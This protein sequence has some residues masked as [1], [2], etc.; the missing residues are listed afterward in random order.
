MWAEIS[1]IAIENRKTMDRS[2]KMK[3]W[4]FDMNKSNKNV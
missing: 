3:N 2:N 1:E 4:F